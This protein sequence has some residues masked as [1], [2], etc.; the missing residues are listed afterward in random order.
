M[1]G[2]FRVPHANVFVDAGRWAVVHQLNGYWVSMLRDGDGRRFIGVHRAGSDYP[3]D[4]ETRAQVLEKCLIN[5]IEP[6]KP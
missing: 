2:P 4:I 6:G 3:V 1:S 5:L